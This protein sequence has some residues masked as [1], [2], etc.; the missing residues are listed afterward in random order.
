MTMQFEKPR[1]PVAKIVKYS[2]V[3]LNFSSS[4]RSDI[5]SHV[6]R[7]AR[8]FRGAITEASRFR[9]PHYTFSENS[10]PKFP[11]MLCSRL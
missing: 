10:N 8:L 3:T 2:D 7:L 1:Y 4:W 5:D 6:K 9:S 11:K